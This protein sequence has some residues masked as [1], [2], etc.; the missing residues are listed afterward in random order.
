M[1]TVN[2]QANAS[3]SSAVSHSVLW[4]PMPRLS[5]GVL[6]LGAILTLPSGVTK[7]RTFAVGYFYLI[8]TA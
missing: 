4:L 5:A 2:Q 8:L 1:G 7:R 6:D 3:T